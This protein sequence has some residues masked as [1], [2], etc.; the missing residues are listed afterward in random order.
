[1]Q[2]TQPLYCWEDVFT[3]AFESNGSYSIVAFI[4]VAAGMCLQS[5]CLAM[6]VYSDF[7]I[8][9]FGRHVTLCLR[10]TAIRITKCHFANCLKERSSPKKTFRHVFG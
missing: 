6:N 1:M 9:A 8:P 3:A 7:I 5:R 10:E 4:F 2:K